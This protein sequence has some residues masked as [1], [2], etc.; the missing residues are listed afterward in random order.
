MRPLS[1]IACLALLAGCAASAAGP[2]PRAK[3]VFRSAES[4]R[5]AEHYASIELNFRKA[6]LFRKDYEPADAPFD[7]N[8]LARHFAHV[9]Q[10]SE[11]H[12]HDKTVLVAG[13]SIPLLRW[14]EPLRI[15]A[16]GLKVADAEHVQTLA[17]RITRLTGLDMAAATTPAESNVQI[18]VLNEESRASLYADFTKHGG[19]P[20]LALTREWPKLDDYPCIAQIF[21]KPE[22]HTLEFALILIKDELSHDYRKACLTEEFVQSLGLFN[23]GPEIR[24]SIFN[25]DAEFIEL[26]RHDEYLLQILYDRRLTPGMLRDEAEPIVREIAAE[27]MADA[28]T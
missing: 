19:G 16:S 5:L 17:G 28:E 18:L 25:D 21:R 27:L 9:A 10:H 23:D 11:T 14:E 2:L 7:A 15:Y 26:T 22:S 4:Q 13:S 20:K 24:P 12:K 3:P 6:G 1:A 8:A